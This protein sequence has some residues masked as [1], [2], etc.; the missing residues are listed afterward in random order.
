MSLMY[1]IFS[2]RYVIN[3]PLLTKALAARVDGFDQW[4]QRRILR[5]VYG[6][7]VTNAEVRNGTGCVP[8]TEMIRSR[9]LTLFGHISRSES[10]MNHCRA[11]RAS[12]IGAPA[13]WKRPRGRPRH[14]WIHTAWRRAQ[15]RSD[16]RTFVRT[17]TLQ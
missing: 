7:H 15:N 4:C 9:R 16:W 5:V 2:E 14:T 10:S 11:L 12:I 6:D 17:A 3:G 1:S 8:T 13:T